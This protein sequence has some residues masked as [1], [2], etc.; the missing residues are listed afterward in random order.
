[1]EKASSRCNLYVYLEGRQDSGM[2]DLAERIRFS[3]GMGLPV[4]TLVS[5]PLF[6]CYWSVSRRVVPIRTPGAFTSLQGQSPWVAFLPAG[7]GVSKVCNSTALEPVQEL[8]LGFAIHWP[9]QTIAFAAAGLTSPAAVLLKD[10]PS[11][12][13]P[14]ACFCHY[15]PKSCASFSFQQMI[16]WSD[17]FL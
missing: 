8:M 11:I 4:P 1:M 17:G 16:C 3:L 9:S 6:Y 15:V 10:T 2:A 5:Q 7:G 13:S 12:W 14:F